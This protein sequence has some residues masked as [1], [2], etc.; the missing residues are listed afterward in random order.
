MQPEIAIRRR[1]ISVPHR[2]GRRQ[3]RRMDASASSARYTVRIHRAHGSYFA[4]VLELPGCVSRGATEVEA[5]ENV[6]AA[7]RA[8]LWVAQLSASD[9][10]T[11]E[12]EIRA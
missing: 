6:R 9:P 11:V 10:A 3:N 8:C 12:L 7:I 4:R 2:V 5:V 1:A